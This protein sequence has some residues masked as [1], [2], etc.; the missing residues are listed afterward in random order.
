MAA[1]YPSSV[2]HQISPM[3]AICIIVR[4]TSGVAGLP[5]TFSFS[6]AAFTFAGN[7]AISS[8]M[9]QTPA[10]VRV[11]GIS[12][13]M[14]P[15]ISQTPVKYTIA[16]AFPKVRGTIRAIPW[17]ARVK[18]ATPVNRNIIANA[19]RVH[20]THEASAVTPNAPT[21]RNS[22]NEANSTIM[23]IMRRILTH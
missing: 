3:K 14:A 23:T 12:I 1:P 9:R 10:S 2:D 6:R 21:A 16:M 5:A 11:R 17:R 22:N 7:I 20:T 13:P 8:K 19:Q 4:G 18:C 15:A